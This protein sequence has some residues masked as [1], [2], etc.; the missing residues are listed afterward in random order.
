M[1]SLY[2]RAYR[3]VIGN[4]DIK[5]IGV[6]GNH[7]IY[8]TGN[9]IIDTKGEVVSNYSKSIK[10][11][12]IKFPNV[13]IL[14]DE[15]FYHD[16]VAYIGLTIV[17]DIVDDQRKFFGD[18]ILGNLFNKDNY[19]EKTIKLLE[20]VPKDTPIVVMSHSP[21]KEYSAYSNKNIGVPSNW[22]FRNYPNVKVYIHG[23]GHSKHEE[24]YIEGILCITNPIIM[25]TYNLEKSYSLNKWHEILRI[26]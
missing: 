14:N 6:L 11:L 23:H 15:V 25:N 8:S 4:I 5:G 13:K 24:E 12:N 26:D 16:G 22:I 1:E 17:Y 2:H 19:I 7:D 18:M 3:P 20:S 21:F 10:D 9:L